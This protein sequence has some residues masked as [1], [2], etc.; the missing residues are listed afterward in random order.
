MPSYATHVE[1]TAQFHAI[2][3]L[4]QLFD[5]LYESSTPKTKLLPII[6]FMAFSLEAYINSIGVRHITDWAE[7]EKLP[8][9]AKLKILHEHRGVVPAWGSEP[10]HFI[11]E[12]FG[13]RNKLAH[14]KSEPV[15]GPVFSTL[16]EANDFI[17]SGN[18]EPNWFRVID[19][20][21]VKSA[22]GR[23]EKSLE[24]LALIYGLS[25]SDYLQ[26]SRAVVLSNL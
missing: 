11:N 15:T 10:L 1:F 18:L 5:S 16:Q 8:W 26:E 9:K 21:W 7:I 24:Y 22:R 19:L 4:H 25:P 2:S 17:F 13:I 14:G 23:F 12:I 3:A 6:V 20:A